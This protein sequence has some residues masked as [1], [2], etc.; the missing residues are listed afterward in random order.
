MTINVDLAANF[1]D[2]RGAIRFKVQPPPAGFHIFGGTLAASAINWGSGAD[3]TW[4]GA[5]PTPAAGYVPFDGALQ[6]MDTGVVEAAAMTI[7]MVVRPPVELQDTLNP[8]LISTNTAVAEVGGAVINGL[9]LFINDASDGR[10]T[11]SATRH[12]GAGVNTQVTTN[13]VGAAKPPLGQWTLLAA[14]IDDTRA[15]LADL[16]RGQVDSA[17]GLTLAR[18]P[19]VATLRIGTRKSTFS[20]IDQIDIHSALIRT[21][22]LS[23]ADLA[24]EA[25]QMRAF[26]A[27]RSI[28]V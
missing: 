9:S 16:T 11:M 22:W 1:S 4:V 19:T 2:Q 18:N 28:T 25:A 12:N 15:Y 8:Y 7:L 24:I 21:A 20:L 3:G 23:D 27:Q 26:A 14:R 10:W 13:L 17:S 6:G 5:A